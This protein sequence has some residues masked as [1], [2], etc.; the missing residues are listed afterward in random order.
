MRRT[1]PSAPALTRSTS[2][3]ETAT[4]SAGGRGSVSRITSMRAMMTV[5]SGGEALLHDGGGATRAEPDAALGGAERDVHGT[6]ELPIA[7]P[8]DVVQEHGGALAVRQ[9]I[10]VAQHRLGAVAA[11]DLLRRRLRGGRPVPGLLGVAIERSG[12]RGARA[13]SV[14]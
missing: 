8:A 13:D 14:Q 6:R 7:E 1:G 5:R 12:A 9:A 4:S 11:D 2:A 3:C 10:E